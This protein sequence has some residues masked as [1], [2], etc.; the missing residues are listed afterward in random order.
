MIDFYANYFG[1]MAVIQNRPIQPE[2][3]GRRGTE[4]V[5]ELRERTKPFCAELCKQHPA[6]EL[7][8]DR[9]LTRAAQ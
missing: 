4:I 3:L 6:A 2:I 8:K 9:L 5:E 1:E 7:A